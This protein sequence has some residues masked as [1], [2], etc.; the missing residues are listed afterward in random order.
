MADPAQATSVIA[1]SALPSPGAT[2][3]EDGRYSFTYLPT[4]AGSY[5]ASVRL[6][7]SGGLLGTYYKGANLTAPVLASRGTW[8]DGLYHRPYW[9]AGVAPGNWSST[10]NFGPAVSCDPSVPGCGCD[11]TRL[12]PTLAFS[13]GTDSPLPYD[14]LYSNKFPTEFYSVQ[15]KGFVGAPATGDYTITLTADYGVQMRVNGATVINAVPMAVASAT[16]TVTLTQGVLAPV[17]IT[18]YHQRD[19]AYFKAEWAGPGVGDGVTPQVRVAPSE[20]A[21]LTFRR[22]HLLHLLNSPFLTHTPPLLAPVLQVIAGQYL[23][24]TRHVINSP[25]TVEVYPGAANAALTTA[26]G[27]GLTN[28]T[29]T[30]PCAF[31]VHARDAS[32]NAIFNNGALPWNVTVYGTGDWAG[33]AGATTRRVDA[34]NYTGSVARL[35]VAVVP[36]PGSWELV[37]VGSAVQ[38]SN[39]LLVVN[40][41]AAAPV[42]RGDTIL[43][44][45]ETMQVASYYATNGQ[46]PYNANVSL[47]T[48]GGVTNLG[49]SVLPLA[50]PYL[51]PSFTH[52]PVYRLRNCT[53][54]SY[55]VTYTPWIRGAYRVNVQ[56]RF[57]AT[58]RPPYRARFMLPAPIRVSL[59]RIHTHNP[60]FFPPGRCLRSTRC[61]RW[62]STRRAWAASAATTPSRRP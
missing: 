29:A 5:V 45:Q 38:Y 18:Y 16:A 52:L 4:R 22:A 9:C 27:G 10:W 17:T 62:P 42:A 31:T 46:P 44:G 59:T 12:D 43:V 55:L 21:P 28:C 2:P 40:A 41:T 26:T 60:H 13:W 36:T 24:H 51:G 58:S 30:Q 50:R 39:T 19:A 25:L 53:T 49:H 34:V 33:Y 35:N 11:S 56:V 57:G 6:T 47:S 32:G 23:F 61:S 14:E 7:T 15:W 8:H 54:G 20:S 37:G 1:A 3:T 48:Y